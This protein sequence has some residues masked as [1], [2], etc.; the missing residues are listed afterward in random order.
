MAVTAAIIGSVAAVGGT[1]YGIIS[2][3]RSRSE[4]KEQAERQQADQLKKENELKERKRAEAE[5]AG[6]AARLS[7]RPET[8]SGNRSGTIL[9]SPLG[10]T[11]GPT[12][13]RKML[14]GS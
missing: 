5:Q 7:S 6:L 14:I 12:G 2:G 8:R 1:T 11:A 9:T 4:A 3:E 13:S 10:I